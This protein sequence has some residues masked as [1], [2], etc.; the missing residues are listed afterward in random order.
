MIA[1]ALRASVE[2]PEL[3]ELVRTAVVM[4]LGDGLSLAAA[5]GGLVGG[6]DQLLKALADGRVAEVAL[7]S[8]A[9]ERTIRSLTQAL[10]GDMLVTTLPLDREALGRRIGSGTRAALGVLPVPA[11]RHLRTQLQRLRRLG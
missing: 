5:S 6:H 8:D 7:A 9:A 3:S 1:K 10:P 2:V 11:T 4:A